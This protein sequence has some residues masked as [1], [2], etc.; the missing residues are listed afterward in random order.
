MD[1]DFGCDDGVVDLQFFH[2]L[3]HLLRLNRRL[4]QTHPLHTQVFHAF[5]WLAIHPDRV[6][7]CHGP[8]HNNH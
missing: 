3:D 7:N 1:F 4:Q 2:V 6:I 5:F 8:G